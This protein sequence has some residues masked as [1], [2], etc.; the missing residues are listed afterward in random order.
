LKVPKWQLKAS[1]TSGNGNG[2]GSG[3]GIGIGIGI[4]NR[5]DEEEA[6]LSVDEADNDNDNDNSIEEQDEDKDEEMSSTGDTASYDDSRK[7][8]PIIV[9]ASSEAIVSTIN[10]AWLDLLELETSQAIDVLDNGDVDVCKN[11]YNNSD[12]DSD[13]DISSDIMQAAVDTVA[14]GGNLLYC[15]IGDVT[16][17]DISIADDA[18]AIIVTL[19]VRIHADAGKG[20]LKFKSN[21][22]S[23]STTKNKKKKKGNN[24]KD[25]NS[26]STSTSTNSKVKLKAVVRQGKDGM[27]YIGKVKIKSM[28]YVSEVVSV[29]REGVF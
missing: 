28:E 25:N 5:N 9:K 11:R 1:A 27:T 17:K 20:I 29:L 16:Q 19:G 26:N 15:G 23:S 7:G 21:A 2:S 8:L 6:D 18:N 13:S 24:A 12:S 10:D 4:G 22:S 14:P 3:I